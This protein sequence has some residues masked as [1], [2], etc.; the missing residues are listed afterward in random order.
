MDGLAGQRGDRGHARRICASSAASRPGRKPRA[1]R[2][3]HRLPVGQGCRGGRRASRGYDAGKKINGRKRHIAVDTIGLLLTV[4]ITAAAIQ[5]RDAAKPLLWNLT[6][7][8]PAIKL[9]WADGIYAGK[10]VAWA[11][12]ALKLTLQIVRRT[13]DLHTF[14]VLP[15]RWVVER[16]L[17]WITRRPTV[18]D[19][20]LPRRRGNSYYPETLV[21][22]SWRC[23]AW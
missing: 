10:L 20:E 6:K 4:L 1:D 17:A 5:D 15:R 21:I 9:A 8:F 23:F 16:T 18:R 11:I 22:P 3:G 7:A 12:T 19:Y 14:I 2:G 13:D